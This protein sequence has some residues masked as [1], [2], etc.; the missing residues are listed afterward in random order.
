[1]TALRS[2]HQTDHEGLI[3]RMNLA[4]DRA[5]QALDRVEQANAAGNTADLTDLRSHVDDLV[6]AAHGFES[7]RNAG[8]SPDD[9]PAGD[10]PADGTRAD[11]SR[12]DGS[13]PKDTTAGT[14]SKS[15]T[16]TQD[17]VKAPAGKS[18]SGTGSA[19]G[20]GKS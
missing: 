8:V 20:S 12:S 2:D 7:L 10:R 11:G 4:A 13:D 3:N 6:S 17:D 15:S 16:G 14:G 1:M 19:S 18:G 5:K 9:S